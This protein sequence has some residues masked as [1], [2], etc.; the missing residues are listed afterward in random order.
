MLVRGTHIGLKLR[1]G[2]GVRVAP[3]ERPLRAPSRSPLT[4]K[5]I[6]ACASGPRQA[7]TR[8]IIASQ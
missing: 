3:S 8:V 6:N 1:T 5:A 2:A 4:L 7:V